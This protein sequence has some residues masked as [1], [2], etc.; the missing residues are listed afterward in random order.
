MLRRPE[1]EPARP[2][3][4]LMTADTVGGVWTYAMELCRPLTELGIQVGLATMGA[5]LNRGQRAEARRI[6][7]LQVYESRYALEWMDEPWKDVARAG[8]W[9]LDLE[10]KLHPDVIHLNGYC[11]GGLPWRAASLIVAHSCVLSWWKAVKRTPVPTK[12]NRYA[13]EVARGLAGANAIVA[14]SRHMLEMLRETYG[15]TGDLRTIYNG[16]S[17]TRFRPGPKDKFV[18]SAGR[19]WDEAKNIA[20]LAESAES[21]AWPVVVAGESRAPGGGRSQFANV[22]MLGQL[23]PR[24]LCDWFSSAAIFALPAKYEPF[25][26]CVLEAAL[27]GCALVLGDI[28]TLHEIWGDAASYVDPGDSEALTRTVN[29]LIA[30]PELRMMMG[31]RALARAQRYSSEAMALRYMDLYTDLFDLHRSALPRSTGAYPAKPAEVPRAATIA[32]A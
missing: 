20:L 1:R 28:E 15:V 23:P 10:R 14:P 13:S 4:I 2:R 5:P 19:V 27:S 12:W 11:H 29:G 7:N 9:L 24:E 26:L 31:A 25:G 8:E 22:N 21:L 18:F 32:I 3:R 16:R 6:P 30:D 17:S